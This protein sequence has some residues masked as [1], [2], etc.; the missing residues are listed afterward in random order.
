MKE[1]N[2][3]CGDCVFFRRDPTAKID[4][5][6]PMF[7]IRKAVLGEGAIKA[8]DGGSAE[9]P[10][11]GKCKAEVGGRRYDFGTTSD[12]PVC[13]AKE[14]HGATLFKHK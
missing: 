13:R 6:S 4:R 14:K 10:V 3:T 12:M 2:Q 8:E 11:Y 1:I 9:P 7:A 5:N